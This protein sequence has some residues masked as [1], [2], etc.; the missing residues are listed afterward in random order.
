M[1]MSDLIIRIVP[2]DAMDVAVLTSALERLRQ[3]SGVTGLEI[4]AVTGKGERID[5]EAV[6]SAIGSIMAV[7]M[8]G[9]LGA[10]EARKLLEELKGVLVATNGIKE[11]WLQLTGKQPVRIEEATAEQVVEESAES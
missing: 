2:D 11:A 4:E 9:R 7:V 5:L 10:A 8:A 6:G 3:L 1:N